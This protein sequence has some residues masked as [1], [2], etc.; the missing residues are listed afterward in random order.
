MYANTSTATGRTPRKTTGAT[1]AKALRSDRALIAPSLIAPSLI[2]PSRPLVEDEPR[3]SIAGDRPQVP[4][5]R[6]A[7]DV[8]V[9]APSGQDELAGG[10]ARARGGQPVVHGS[11]EVVVAI[12]R[13][14]EELRP[15]ELVLARQHATERPVRAGAPEHGDR[16]ARRHGAVDPRGCVRVAR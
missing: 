1:A 15:P 8:A 5:R 7:E 2:A 3:F 11:P 14:V 16:A 10:D 12:D 9:A 4:E 6:R 13:P